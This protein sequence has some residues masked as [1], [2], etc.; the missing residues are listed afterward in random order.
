MTAAGP[1]VGQRY[2]DGCEA[3]VRGDLVGPA[4]DLNTLARVP[5]LKAASGEGM[6]NERRG[7][8]PSHHLRESRPLRSW[9][10]A[11]GERFKGQPGHVGRD[12]QVARLVQLE[13]VLVCE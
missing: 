8:R 5:D 1:S 4:P 11:T 2:T 12:N 9:P 3:R 13:G 6:A 10:A 7:V